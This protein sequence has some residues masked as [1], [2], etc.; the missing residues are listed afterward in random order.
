VS[1][2]PTDL[3]GTAPVVALVLSGQLDGSAAAAVAEGY[4]AAVA[5]IPPPATVVLD[6]AAVD[7][8]NSTGI[9][10][11]VGVL[12]RARAAGHRVVAVGLTSHYRHIFDVTRLSD[13][14]TVAEDAR[15]V[16]DHSPTRRVAVP[17]PREDTR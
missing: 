17:P 13:F 6:F 12:G 5:G 1:T 14:L 9:A 11:V 16:T 8:I 2:A 10:V 7:Y 15:S 3:A 4:A